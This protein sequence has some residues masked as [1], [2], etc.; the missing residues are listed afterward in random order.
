MASIIIATVPVH[1]HVS[2]LLHVARHFV[3]R[4]DTVRFVTGARFADAVAATGARHIPLP[5]EADFD[6]RLDLQET[7]PERA[8]LKGARAIAFDIENVFVRPGHAQFDAVWAACG[9]EP[10]AAVLMDTAFLGGAFLLGRPLGARPRSS[11]AGSCRCPSP[12]AI[13]PP[14]AWG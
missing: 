10:T 9:D 2:P 5:I 8:A 6:D 4:G 1:G 13:R 3:K 7:Y 11:C 12:V 14:T